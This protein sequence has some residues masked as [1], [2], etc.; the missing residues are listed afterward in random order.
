MPEAGLTKIMERVSADLAL[1]N[2][3]RIRGRKPNGKIG[4][5]DSFMGRVVPRGDRKHHEYLLLELKRPSKVVGR[6]ELDQLEDYVA[7][8]LS[9]PDFLN[10]ATTWTFY[11]VTT[12]YDEMVKGRITQKDRPVGVFLEGSNYTVWVKTWAELL[13]ECEA[14]LDFVQEKLRVEVSGEEIEQRISILKTS[15]LKGGRERKPMAAPEPAQ[16]STPSPSP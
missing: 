12:E 16:K 9:Q 10:T 14:R 1:D 15:I 11:L 4:R 6:K 2:R 7:S 3:G 13:R 5:I 8:I